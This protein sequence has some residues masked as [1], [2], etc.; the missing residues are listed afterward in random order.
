M[1]FA[2][3]AMPSWLNIEAYMQGD[4]SES[5]RAPKT[6]AKCLKGY[7]VHSSID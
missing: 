3:R 5:P 2:Y 4:V 1:W 7:P 6:K